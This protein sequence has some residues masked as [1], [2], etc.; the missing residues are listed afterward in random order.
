[1][2]TVTLHIYST[3]T[4]PMVRSDGQPFAGGSNPISDSLWDN[5]AFGWQTPAANVALTFG[6]PNASVSFDDGDGVLSAEGGAL[7]DATVV[8]QRLVGANTIDGVSYAGNDSTILWETPPAIYVRAEFSVVLRDGDGNAY[9]MVGVSIVAGYAPTVV[10][11]V[12][13]G[14]HPAPGAVL[15]YNLATSPNDFNPAPDV[16]LGAICYAA[17]TLIE[18]TA[19]EVPVETL[20][21]GMLVVT[22]DDGLQPVLWVGAQVL[23]AQRLA[24]APHLRPV[25]IRAGALG[26]GLPRRDL[27]VSPQHRILVRSRIARRMFGADEV[28][29]PARALLAVDGIDL[30]DD[31]PAVTYVHF[32]LP[33]HQVVFA[34]G[35]EAESLFTGARAM[36]MLGA[37]ARAEIAAIFPDLALGAAARPL[38]PGAM[39]RKLAGR[40]A[41]NARPL[42][43]RA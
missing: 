21:P 34:E 4:I 2:A 42:V 30:A 24:Q 27:V 13:V 6:S 40:H 35:A 26:E 18:T 12:F 23:D 38:V 43:G 19:G 11:V 14:A 32:L 5:N 29:V 9:T 22:R 36:A 41:G 31:L 7:S 10:G 16:P 33:A 15:Y 1:M 20:R 25:R 39:A 17:G 8:D 28:L 37:T 3:G